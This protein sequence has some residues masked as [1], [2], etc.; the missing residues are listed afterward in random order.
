[1]RPCPG[2]TLPGYS[3]SQEYATGVINV[4]KHSESV[5]D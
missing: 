4:G 5:A 2:L 1:M 3:I